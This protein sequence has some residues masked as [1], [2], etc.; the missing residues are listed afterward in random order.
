MG[1]GERHAAMLTAARDLFQQRGYAAV[2]IGDVAAAVGVT[3]AAVHYHFAT[4]ADLYA[5]VMRSVL[6][7]IERGI[8]QMSAAPASVTAKLHQLASFA[9]VSLRSN[10]DLDAMMR[11]ADEHLSPAHQQEI[12]Q[13]HAG[14]SAALAELMRDGMAA[15]ELAD[16]DPELLAHAFWHLL[17]GFAGRAGAVQGYQGRPEI[18][19]AVV[20][21]FLAGAGRRPAPRGDDQDEAA[22]P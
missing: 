9:V 7:G 10:A 8:R 1:Q 20:E 18:A 21:L 13:A 2:S 17:G 5:A 4:K 19:T 15:G 14:V 3:K 16:A 22:N 12:H 6:A 11:D